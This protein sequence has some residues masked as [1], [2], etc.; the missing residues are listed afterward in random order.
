MI[1]ST[2]F[3]SKPQ[4]E[5]SMINNSGITGLVQVKSGKWP[6]PLNP[7]EYRE[8]LRGCNKIYLFTTHPTPYQGEPVENV[9][10]LTRSGIVHWDEEALHPTDTNGQTETNATKRLTRLLQQS[11]KSLAR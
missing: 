9:I 3:R 8:Y 6:S 5:F 4:F 1:K 11:A 10:C 2:C 7:I